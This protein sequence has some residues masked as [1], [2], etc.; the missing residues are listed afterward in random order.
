MSYRTQSVS[1]RVTP[2]VHTY[3][4]T[5]F[6][7]EHRDYGNPLPHWGAVYRLLLYNGWRIKNQVPRDRLIATLQL[8]NRGMDQN[9]HFD[10]YKVLIYIPKCDIENFNYLREDA[11]Q[12]HSLFQGVS[13]FY[14][15]LVSLG[16]KQHK[17]RS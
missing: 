13:N 8:W 12:Y 15:L 5:H 10:G 7:P 9:E 1:F 2:T 11:H 6:T 4:L 14:R 16:I 3:V 17:E